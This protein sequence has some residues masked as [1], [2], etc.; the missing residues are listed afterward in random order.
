MSCIVYILYSGSSDKYY[1]GQTTNL[2]ERLFRHNNGYEK[3]TKGGSPWKLVWYAE[4]PDRSSA[5]ILEKKL[6]N[7]SRKKL[8]EFIK[9]NNQIAGH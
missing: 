7:L 3:S 2:E 4:K 9:K 5:M 8:V 6:K 1:K